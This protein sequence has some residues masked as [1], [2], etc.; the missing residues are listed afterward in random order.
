MLDNAAA[1]T[2]LLVPLGPGWNWPKNPSILLQKSSSG[3]S[4][5]LG[6]RA[7]TTKKS[8]EAYLECKNKVAL[9]GWEPAAAPQRRSRCPGG[10]RGSGAPPSGDK[11]RCA[12]TLTKY[13]EQHVHTRPPHVAR[14]KGQK[15]TT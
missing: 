13:P 2:E 3:P 6:G 8:P 11:R 12:P 1:V 4:S 9:R 10:V 14:Q 5:E 15:S 7:R